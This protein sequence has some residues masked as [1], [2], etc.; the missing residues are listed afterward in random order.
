MIH[1]II[2]FA[3]SVHVIYSRVREF[4]EPCHAALPAIATPGHSARREAGLR[5]G[6]FVDEVHAAA[7][8]ANQH[9][10]V[11]AVLRIDGCAEPVRAL[12]GNLDGMLF[13]AGLSKNECYLE[14]RE[15]R[16]EELF[17]VGLIGICL[18]DSDWIEWPR[19][20]R[21][22]VDLPGAGNLLELAVEIVVEVV[23]GERTHRSLFVHGIANYSLLQVF[24]ELGPED[25]V[26][27]SYEDEPFWR[28]AHLP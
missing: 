5:L 10:S 14:E 25:F 6:N 1:P 28:E 11:I 12:V 22:P 15:D 17:V 20:L 24:D 27:A 18:D 16:P 4:A 21:L 7:H 2:C 13:I 19:R 26:G 3:S 8:P 9:L 23:S